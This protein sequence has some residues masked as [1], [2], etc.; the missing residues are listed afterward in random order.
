MY[1]MK[2]KKTR[3]NCRRI[4]VYKG[5]RETSWID[6]AIEMN[7]NTTNRTMKAVFM[8]ATVHPIL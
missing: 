4:V 7:V 8:L 6:F 2:D 3:R 1:L 5:V